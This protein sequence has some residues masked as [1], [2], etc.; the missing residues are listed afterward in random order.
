MRYLVLTVLFS[1]FTLISVQ[2]QAACYSRDEAEA[3]QGIRLHSELMV[4]GLNCQHL[5][6]VNGQNLYGAYRDFTSKHEQLFAEYE[7]VMLRYYET[8][9]AMSPEKELNALRTEF[10]NDIS[11]AAAASRP[12]LFCQDNA[13]RISTA[14]SMNKADIRYWATARD[15]DHAV[16]R[17]LCVAGKF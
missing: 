13:P 3:E 9:G 4:I 6:Q 2:A 14:V 8:T 15:N 10:A 16:S 1:V 17:E 11:M 5:F 12:D 7:R